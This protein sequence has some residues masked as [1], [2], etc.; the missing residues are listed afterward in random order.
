[1]TIT[2]T[3]V[4]DNQTQQAILNQLFAGGGG[5][6]VTFG[7]AVVLDT[8]IARNLGVSGAGIFTGG[9]GR[10]LTLK[11]DYIVQNTANTGGAGGI[12]NAGSPLTLVHTTI[13]DNIPNDCEGTGCP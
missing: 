5:G 8:I 13:K 3:S 9:S 1:V 7:T 12:D 6:M 11:N 4:V 2:S 10:P